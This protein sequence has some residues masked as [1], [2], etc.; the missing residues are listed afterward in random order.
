MKNINNKN[1]LVELLD[2][3]FAVSGEMIK[4]NGEDSY[5]FF[6]ND[7]Y[8]MIAVFDGCGGIGSRRY[9]LY[10]DKTGAY[11]ASHTVAQVAK[12]WFEGFSETDKDLNANT[13][14]EICHDLQNVID[15]AL[16]SVRTL[17]SSSSV[18]KASRASS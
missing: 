15:A 3:V 13:A 9:A 4:D 18:K 14:D 16:K 12:K 11:I 6:V 5:A 17:H 2:T 1:S 7:K 10:D 8:G